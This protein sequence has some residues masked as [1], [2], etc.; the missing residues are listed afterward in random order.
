MLKMTLGTIGNL[1]HSPPKLV[2]QL[3]KL[4]LTGGV[5]MCEVKSVATLTMSGHTCLIDS[6]VEA[7]N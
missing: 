1:G 4:M 5:M 2:K 7:G 3:S 6:E